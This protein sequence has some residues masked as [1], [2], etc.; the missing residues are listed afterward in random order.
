MAEQAA[1]GYGGFWIRFLAYVVDGVLL[2]IVLFGVLFASVFLGPVGGVVIMV[3]PLLLPLLYFTL[4][5]ASP[6]QATLGKGLLGLKVGRE[7]ERLSIGRSLGRELAKFVSAL[8]LMIGFLL[9]AFTGRKQALHDF[10]ASTT[11]VREGPSHVVAALAIALVGILAPIIL[12]MVLGVGMLAAAMGGA[13]MGLMAEMMKEQEKTAQKS[14]PAK[15][16]APSP[17]PAQAVPAKPA[18]PAPSAASAADV[19]KL[20]APVAGIDK[21]ATVRAGPAVLELSTFFSGTDPKVWIRVHAPQ[22]VSRAT[23]TISQVADGANQSRYDPKNRFETEFF[24]NVSLSEASGR[25]EGL[26]SVSLTAGTTEQQVQKVDGVLKLQVPVGTR[27]LNLQSGDAGKVQS[28]GATTLVMHSFK[29]DTVEIESQGPRDNLL[30]MRGLNAKGE[31]VAT[32]MT[33]W[34]SGTPVRMTTKFKGPVDRVELQVAAEIVERSYPFALARGG[35]PVAAA[36]AA[37]APKA[38]AGPAPAPAKPPVVAPVPEPIKVAATPVVEAPKPNPAPRKRAAAPKPVAEPAAAAPAP[39][40]VRAAAPARVVLPAPKYSDL[41]SAVLARDAAGV[42]ELLDFGKWADKPDRR[43]ATPLMV[44]VNL[45]DAA[46]AEAL[47]KGGANADKA[48]GVAQ[49]R[50]DPAMLGLLQRYGAT[51]PRPRP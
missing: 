25:K 16:A 21:P 34:S 2:W 27:T 47:L 31:A 14:A 43:G 1:A 19:D 50:R 22:A 46:S 12:V 48:M 49:E 44:A 15:P 7:G 9:A 10:I 26:R 11:V 17:A 39:A 3:A 8:P 35:A 45:G 32:E 23:V 20:L 6:R 38:A 29:G 24:Q 41:M 36:P 42:Q 40:P 5:Q 51:L 28:V 37:P 33:S 13:G 18:A 4:M 30:Q